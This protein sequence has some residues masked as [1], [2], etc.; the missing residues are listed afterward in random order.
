MVIW[1]L[2]MRKVAT[3]HE[4]ETEWSFDDMM[5]AVAVVGMQ[6]EGERLV[7]ELMRKKMRQR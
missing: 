6:A 7:S 1:D 3:L 2:V 4:L 5:R